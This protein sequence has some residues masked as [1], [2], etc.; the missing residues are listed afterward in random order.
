VERDDYRRQ[1]D[2]MLASVNDPSPTPRPDPSTEAAKAIA[3]E[4]NRCR[5]HLPRDVY[6]ALS[7]EVMMRSDPNATA[8]DGVHAVFLFDGGKTLVSYR[9]GHAVVQ[10][11]QDDGSVHVVAYRYGES[12]GRVGH[13]R[14]DLID[15][16]GGKFDPAD[17][18]GPAVRDDLDPRRVSFDV[19]RSS[20]GSE[21]RPPRGGRPVPSHTPGL[22]PVHVELDQELDHACLVRR[23][24]GGERDQRVELGVCIEDGLPGRPRGLIECSR[25]GEEVLDVEGRKP[26]RH[27]SPFAA[28]R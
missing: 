28:G 8:D 13:A 19:E 10:R 5:A 20:V 1:I 9:D 22:Y 14:A 3:D 7:D 27:R 15:G 4:W 23:G 2:D 11:Q 12:S 25:P 24:V 16:F 26:N 17:P 18:V 6:E 21:P